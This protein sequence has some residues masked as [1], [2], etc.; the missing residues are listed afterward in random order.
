MHFQRQIN[1]K[2]KSVYNQTELENKKNKNY[3]LGINLVN[4]QL[5]NNRFA[6]QQFPSYY[7]NN[8]KFNERNRKVKKAIPLG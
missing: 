1:Q 2:K 4:S 7:G 8:M 5:N 6:N 3:N